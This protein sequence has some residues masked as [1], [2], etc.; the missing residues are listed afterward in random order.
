M[1]P[2]DLVTSYITCTIS[3][4]APFSYK[5]R[6]QEIAH[7]ITRA[8]RSR[9]SRRRCDHLAWSRQLPSA[10]TSGSDVIHHDD[11]VIS[12]QRDK[13]PVRAP[14]APR[15]PRL[16]HGI[17]AR[18]V[19][20]DT[21]ADPSTTRGS[22]PISR[23]LITRN[24]PQTTASRR[25]ASHADT[26]V[27]SHQLRFSV[28]TRS[29]VDF[30]YRRDT[31]ETSERT[32]VRRCTSHNWSAIYFSLTAGHILYGG[33]CHRIHLTFLSSTELFYVNAEYWITEPLSSQ[34]FAVSATWITSCL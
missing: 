30:V 34:W 27:L 5:T 12:N 8:A 17:C 20:M 11:S 1:T 4:P 16:Q 19:S 2:A 21:D 3:Q 7:S 33:C 13:S 10:G 22:A 23:T 25:V 6:H 15:K 14:D 31:S 28:H 24:R 26:F 32:H 9:S 18:P 29:E